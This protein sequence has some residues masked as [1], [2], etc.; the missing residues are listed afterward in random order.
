MSEY[1]SHVYAVNARTGA[2]VWQNNT[3]DTYIKAGMRQGFV[4]AGYMTIIGNTLWIRSY[5][6]RDGVFDLAT[7]RLRALPPVLVGRT[8]WGSAGPTRRG[9]EIGVLGTTQVFTGGRYVFCD[10]RERDFFG[11]GMTFGFN[12]LDGDSAGKYPE[13]ELT[14]RMAATPAWDDQFIYITSSG[15]GRLTK[16]RIADLQAKTDS[17]RQSV[18]AITLSNWA[19]WKALVIEGLTN[20]FSRCPASLW[21][22]TDITVNAVA[23]AANAVVATYAKLPINDAISHD[24]WA[25]Y[26]GV[27]DK[28]TGNALWETRLP[29]GEPLHQG[30]AIDRNG[31]IIVAMHDGSMVC[32]GTGTVNVARQDVMGPPTIASVNMAPSAEGYTPLPHAGAASSPARVLSVSAVGEQ[33][34]CSAMPVSASCGI[35]PDYQRQVIADSSD[36]IVLPD[37]LRTHTLSPEVRLQRL[38][39]A[40]NPA[41]MSWKPETPCLPV[42]SVISSSASGKVNS[43][44]KTLDRDLRTRWSPSTAGEQWL[45]YDLGAVREVSSVSLVWYS[46]RRQQIPFGVALSVDGRDYRMVDSGTLE[47]RGTS[48]SLRTI[49]AQ[50]ARFVRISFI[51]KNSDDLPSVQE[52]GIHG[53]SSVTQADGA[54]P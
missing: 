26:V 37:G 49:L 1:G 42:A 11:R 53:A 45:T 43:A 22:R 20:D 15:N 2:L 23:V 50:D 27:L 48:E 31:S 29:A 40:G 19:D 47:G 14:D 30:L 21:A 51:P 34:S 41:D 10:Q 9:R 36:V 33:S 46:G 52:V 38:Q 39:D 44:S 18:G 5:R 54:C 17:V 13:V 12:T 8:G 6:G 28:N 25:W 3:S 24:Q 16:W 4:P 7:G 35:A 32:Y